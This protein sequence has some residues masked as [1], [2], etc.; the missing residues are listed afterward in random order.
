VVVPSAIEAIVQKLLEK[1]PDE[2]YEDAAALMDALDEVLDGA[3]AAAAPLTLAD[4]TPVFPGPSIAPP[5][6]SQPSYAPP[7]APPAMGEFSGV[8]AA[9]TAK[10]S[11]PPSARDAA[12]ATVA[13]K[14]VPAPTP[15]PAPLVGVSPA[16]APK[17]QG[18]RA[19]VVVAA[20]VAIGALAAGAFVVLR[21]SRGDVGA[22]TAVD[23]PATATTATGRGSTAKPSSPAGAPATEAPS[24]SSAAADPGV[25]PS[26]AA[27]ASGS[28]SAAPSASAGASSAHF[29]GAAMRL[30]LRR[31]TPARDWVRATDAFFALVDHDA[32]AFHEPAI[33]VATRDLA[34][35]A[36]LAGG[37]SADRIF[38]A[39]AHRAGSDGLDV[40]YELV[41]TRGGSKAATR[42]M[43]LLGK[44]DV[45]ARATPELKVTL[46]LRDAPCSDKP[47]L[48]DRAVAEG[49]LR[50]L[51]VM[52]TVAAAC[53]GKS[54]ALENAERA[55]KQRLR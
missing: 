50:T 19:G 52:Q 15:T 2:R 48:L 23:T 6:G 41:R 8:V 22:Q 31:S 38:D 36:A 26:G 4:G 12:S 5:P 40:L 30:L 1:A 21:S 17:P 18:S 35:N 27:A 11:S 54:K 44:S 14:S 3:P 32:A 28:P 33:L 45:I 7:A 34:A 24:P 16:A 39:L 53:L 42:A 55:L 46:A 10:A 9:A 49:D 43:E 13:A 29:D 51:V 25:A 20:V 47:A 37:D